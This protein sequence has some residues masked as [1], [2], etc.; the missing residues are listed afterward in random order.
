MIFVALENSLWPLAP[1]T[2]CPSLGDELCAGVRWQ[3]RGWLR[4]HIEWKPIASQGAVHLSLIALCFLHWQEPIVIEVFCSI[5][6]NICTSTFLLLTLAPQPIGSKSFCWWTC[7]FS[8][9]CRWS[10]CKSSCGLPGF[11]LYP[12]SLQ[13]QVL[14]EE[15][16]RGGDRVQLQLW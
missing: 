3:R 9:S 11:N 12:K 1:F 4:L 16:I 8:H 5:A 2:P 13:M 7:L 15:S 14:E 6:F 10:F